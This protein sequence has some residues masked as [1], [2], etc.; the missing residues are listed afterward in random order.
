MCSGVCV[1]RRIDDANCYCV[2]TRSVLS[3]WRA[4]V[5]FMCRR[6]L[7]SDTRLA[8]VHQHHVSV[9]LCVFGWQLERHVDSVRYWILLS[10][11]HCQRDCR[12]ML[13]E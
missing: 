1:C 8:V 7:L 11:E 4:F 13:R 2:S 3:W 9:R 10:I 5:Q 12:Q 6:L